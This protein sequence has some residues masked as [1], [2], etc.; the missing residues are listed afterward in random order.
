[1]STA[2]Q[3]T[4]RA[5]LIALARSLVRFVVLALLVATVSLVA[6]ETIYRL[7]WVDTYRGELR[8]YN[9]AGDLAAADDRPV[10][11]FMGDSVTAGAESY[12][13]LLRERR[14]DLRI[15]NAAIPGSSV[16]QANLV[17]PARF[18]RFEPSVFVY[19]VNVGN[20]LLNLRY[21][22]NWR[23]LS[24][25]RNAYWTLVHR[26]RSIEYL[27][28]KSAQFV[29]SVRLRRALRELDASG[30]TLDDVRDTRC[31][32]DSAAFAPES[33]TPR[34]RRYIEAEP[35]LYRDQ[36]LVAP[37]RLKSYT[38]F[39]DG[40]E[41]LLR[42]CASPDCRAYVLV[43]PHA[44]QVD[45]EYLEQFRTLGAHLDDRSAILAPEY[46]FLTGLR[47]DLVRQGRSDAQVLDALPALRAV[48]RDGRRAF[49][50]YDPHLNSCGQDALAE[51]VE[52]V[53]PHRSDAVDD[54]S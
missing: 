22:V 46:P 45:A 40:L 43:V 42:N 12:P 20:D 29:R 17:A 30:R 14:A 50:R 9:V 34:V 19:Q 54:G 36:T 15:I 49:Y 28:Y 11:L 37:S 26:A 52:A 18:E 21:P 13:G 35:G 41:R 5:R 24:L 51:F 16:I 3:P 39:L 53:L 8:E 1:M 27:N 10:V 23:R 4:P 7:Q 6:L 2:S 31:L 47:R 25:A 48:E 33:Y 38:R 32:H 44:S